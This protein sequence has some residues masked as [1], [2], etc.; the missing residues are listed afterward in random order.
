MNPVAA[1]TVGKLTG[2]MT[3]TVAI[4]RLDYVERFVP[5]G[6]ADVEGIVEQKEDGEWYVRVPQ[7]QVIFEH[8][9]PRYLTHAAVF[10]F[11]AWRPVV[12]EASRMPQAPFHKNQIVTLKIQVPLP[13][14]HHGTDS[15]ES[16][17]DCGDAG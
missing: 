17:P 14:M 3:V 13:E 8:D 1:V 9:S 16:L 5:F 15:S 2:R 10:V 12:L 7:C 11:D 4:G 6:T